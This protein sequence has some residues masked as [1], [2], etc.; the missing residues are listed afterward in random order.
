M[1]EMDRKLLE[2]YLAGHAS[3]E[4]NARVEAWLAEDPERW[5]Q[6]AAL[7]DA[8][9][10]TELSEGA[11]DVAMAEVWVRLAPDIGEAGAVPAASP[12]RARRA[13]GGFSLAE[14]RGRRKMVLGQ[15]AAALVL[16]TVGGWLITTLLLRREV[17]RTV[18]MRVATTAPAERAMFRL[19]DGTRVMLGVASTLRYPAGFTDGPRQVSLDG[20]AYFDVVYQQDRPFIVRAGDLVAE[21]LGTQ[22]TMRAYPDDAGARVVVREGRVA[23]RAAATSAPKRV[24]AP[25]QLGRL[26]A[27]QQ[28]TVEAADTA[29]YFAWTQGRLVLDQVPLREALPQ[30]G[31]WFDLDFRLADSTLA[32]VPLSATLKTQPTTEVLNNLAA[33]LGMRQRQVGRTVTLYS[34][35]PNQ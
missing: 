28:P 19:P 17:A 35:D 10:D 14:T 7:R 34:A 31:R 30:L 16:L 33:S 12:S 4:E 15:L 2:R 3:A 6:L 20:E 29:D 8:V 25:G 27:G 1:S 26:R 18:A 5:G 22:F 13:T 9:A 32:R 11:I 23:I 24:I 21:D